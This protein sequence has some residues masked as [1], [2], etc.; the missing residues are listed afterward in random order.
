M[1][2]GILDSECVTSFAVKIKRFKFV[3]NACLL[4]ILLIKFPLIA[5]DV[6]LKMDTARSY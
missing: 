4:T 2:D 1:A 3:S 5:H 6:T